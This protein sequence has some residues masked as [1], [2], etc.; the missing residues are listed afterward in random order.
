MRAGN[1]V[2]SEWSIIILEPFHKAARLQKVTLRTHGTVAARSTGMESRISS[3]AHHPLFGSMGGTRFSG[4]EPIIQTNRPGVHLHPECESIA[5]RELCRGSRVAVPR[6][7]AGLI[8]ECNEPG[9][10]RVDSPRMAQGAF[11]GLVDG[12]PRKIG[13]ATCRVRGPA[14]DAVCRES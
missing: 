7:S 10:R 8:E 11:E 13:F 5:G 2:C 1:R 14:A 4:P 12:P 9:G 3:R 6:V